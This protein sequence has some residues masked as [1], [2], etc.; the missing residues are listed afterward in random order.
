[1]TRDQNDISGWYWVIYKDFNVPTVVE[2]RFETW[3]HTR[4]G[5]RWALWDGDEEVPPEEWYKYRFIQKIEAPQFPYETLEI[6]PPRV[7]K[8]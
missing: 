5:D 2:I 8:S 6:S 1:M 3:D 4:D 7:D